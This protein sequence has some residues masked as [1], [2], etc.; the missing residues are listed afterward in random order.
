MAQATKKVITKSASDATDPVV[1]RARTLR[2]LWDA[3][4]G[5]DSEAFAAK[6]MATS[7]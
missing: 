4:D 3:H 2:A 1:V 7:R 5:A 6:K